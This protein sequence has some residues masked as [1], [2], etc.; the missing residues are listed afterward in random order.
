M[1]LNG[2]V[3]KLEAR[4]GS[5]EILVAFQ[6]PGGL[7]HWNGKTMT[8]AEFKTICQARPGNE[9]II[10]RWAAKHELQTELGRA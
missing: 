10:V 2:R 7:V 5:D 4:T 3:A 9:P 1:N 8:E 6:E